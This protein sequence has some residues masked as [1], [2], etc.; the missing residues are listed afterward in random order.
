MNEWCWVLVL[1]LI[2]LGIILYLSTL[3]SVADTV[4]KLINDKVNDGGTKSVKTENSLNEEKECPIN[5]TLIG[6]RCVDSKFETL[7]RNAMTVIYKR[8]FKKCRPL[9]LKNPLTNRPLELDGWDGEGV[10]FEAQGVQHYEYPNYFH[11]N[12]NE[13]ITQIQRDKLKKERCSERGIHLICIPYTMRTQ[14]Q[15]EEYISKHKK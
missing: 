15:I 6:D 13:Y 8:Q 3:T 9:W 1:V 12:F 4:T 11:R 2:A 10:A 5:T 14:K 7:C